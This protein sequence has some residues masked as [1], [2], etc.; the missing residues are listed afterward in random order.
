MISAF[1][2]VTDFFVNDSRESIFDL[3]D[4]YSV[5]GGDITEAGLQMTQELAWS[6][7]FTN[8]EDHKQV[9]GKFPV[10]VEDCGK[11][12]LVFYCRRGPKD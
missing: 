5:R 8:E 10:V 7:V 6:V 11:R 9:G 12:A 4:K 3:F 1:D 2:S